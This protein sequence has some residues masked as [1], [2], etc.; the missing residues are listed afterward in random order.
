MIAKDGLLC[1]MYAGYSLTIK[2]LVI[3]STLTP[4]SGAIKLLPLGL[5]SEAPRNL[6]LMDVRFIISQQEFDDYLQ[7]F[8]KQL[9]STDVGTGPSMLTVS[10]PFAG[11]LFL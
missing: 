1:G 5:V 10:G 7:L 9:R 3:S 4:A 11:R 6:T 8:S 2:R